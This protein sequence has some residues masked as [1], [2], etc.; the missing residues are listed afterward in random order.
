LTVKLKLARPSL[1]RLLA[2]RR[3]LVLAAA[4]AAGLA[5]LAAGGGGGLDAA[6]RNVR[7]AI[8]AHPASGEIHVVEIDGKSIAEIDRW[9]LPR[10]VHAEAVDRLRE[11]GAR[12]IAFDVDFSNP[13]QPAEDA[14]LAAAL[15]RAGQIAILPTFR[16]LAGAESDRFID[17]A[18]LPAFARHAFL[19]AANVMPDEDGHLRHMPYGL[20]TLGTPRPSLAAMMAET[21]GESGTLFKIDYAIDPATIPRHSLSDLVAGRVPAAALKGKRVIIGATAVEVGD[22]FPTPRHGVLPGVVIQAL[23]AETLLSGPPPQTASGLWPL[24]LAM[25]AIALALRGEP[26]A[27]RL[28][29]LGA[30]AAVLLVLPLAAEWRLA[31]YI[32]LAPALAALAVAALLAGSAVFA[33]RFR[34]S[35]ETDGGTGLAN[36]AGLEA[37]AAR[38]GQ[39]SIVVARIDGFPA[40]ASALGPT[41]T[42]ALVQL[43][44][45]RLRFAAGAE[46]VYRTDEASLAWIDPQ[47]GASETLDGIAAMMRA[48]AHAGQAIDVSLHF[49]SASGEGG[50]AAQVVA[51]A[52]LAAAQAA[53]AGRRWL[54]FSEDHSQEAKRNLALLAELDGAMERGELWNAYQPKLDLASGRI[55]GVEALVRWNHPQRGLIAPDAFI[56]LVEEHG[57]AGDLTLHIIGCALEDGAR[58]EEA[59]HSLHVAVNVSATLLHDSA[60]AESLR[61]LLADS[62]FPPERVTIEVTESAAMS[63]PEAAVAALGRWR[64][65]GVGVS[66][67]DYGTGQ[68]SLS[69]LQTL[70]ATELKIDRSFVATI[71]TEK[72]NAIMVRSTIALAHELGLKVVAEGVEDA[73]CLELLRTMRCDVAQGYHIGRPMPADAMAVFLQGQRRAA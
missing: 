24:L 70:P 22:R 30:G 17:T 34:E 18:P 60:F 9:P 58:W 29:W 11:A 64:E 71:E 47:G 51:N 49:G 2:L 35:A 50:E 7:D 56:P 45:E 4:A 54:A 42:T 25:A 65:L 36:I 62:R 68:S 38:L 41:A 67:D 72:R 63:S 69:Y 23:A 32:P 53:K 6:L 19:A 31:L 8:R 10:G 27:R 39:V 48:A 40:I 21:T 44:A 37:D 13:S 3:P 14:K 52:A 20:E 55:G 59:G 1:A 43:M 16:Q 26:D 12:T 61:D 33:T 28:G 15:E 5:T 46:R 73:A 66:I 57:R